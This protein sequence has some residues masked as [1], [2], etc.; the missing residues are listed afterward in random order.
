MKSKGNIVGTIATL[1]IAFVILSIS[2]L[3]GAKVEHAYSPMVFSA[4]EENTKPLTVDYLLA[5]QGKIGPDNPLWY[6]KVL[7]DKVWYLTTFDADK[8]AELNLLFADKR[9]NSAIELFRNNKPDLGISTLT[10][11]EKYLEKAVPQNANNDDYL[12]RLALSS[13]KHREVIEKEIT[14]LSPEDIKPEAIKVEN[15]SKETYNKTRDLM[16]SK[17]LIPPQNIFESK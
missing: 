8:K 13:L 3:K 11:A 4:K 10:K 5:Y 1:I 9:I 14:P 2:V 17:G 7:R 6:L 16:L 12:R 15:Y